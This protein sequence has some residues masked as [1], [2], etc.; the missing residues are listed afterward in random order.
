MKNPVTVNPLPSKVS[1]LWIQNSQHWDLQLINDIFDYEAVQAITSTIPV[2]SQQQD[3]LRWTQAP[4]GDYS[5]KQIYKN[6]GC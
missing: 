1:D 2:P 6:S 5:T 4:K 3:T